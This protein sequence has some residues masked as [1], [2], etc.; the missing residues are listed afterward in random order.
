M[1]G[2]CRRGVAVYGEHGSPHPWASS[3]VERCKYL[4]WRSPD[5]VKWFST[6]VD[7]SPEGPKNS[8]AQAM[9]SSELPSSSTGMSTPQYAKGPLFLEKDQGSQDIRKA[10]DIGSIRQFVDFVLLWYSFQGL[11]RIPLT[12]FPISHQ[13]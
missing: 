9:G 10:S 1:R 12:Y 8:C 6:S 5:R 13:R 4:R 11:G 7:A 3:G 2:V